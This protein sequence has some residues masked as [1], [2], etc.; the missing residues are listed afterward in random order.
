MEVTINPIV[1]TPTRQLP[2]ILRSRSLLT[3]AIGFFFTVLVNLI[4][5]LEAQAEQL[6]EILFILTGVVMAKWLGVDFINAYKG[7]ASKYN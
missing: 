6:T 5:V 7:V 1:E 2:D 4:P 3:G